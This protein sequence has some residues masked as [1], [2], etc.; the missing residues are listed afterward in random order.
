MKVTHDFAP[1]ERYT[2]DFGVCSAS[3]GWAQIDTSSDAHYF[4]MWC[5]PSSLQVFIYCEGDTTLVQLD[6]AVDFVDYLHQ[7]KMYDNWRG[8]DCMCSPTI[9][10]ALA[11]VGG[12]EFMHDDREREAY[13]T[14]EAFK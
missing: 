6:S 10:G 2:Y 9:Y 1:S 12:L 14:G 4:G 7:L 13:A 8:V 3:K 5:N 11:T